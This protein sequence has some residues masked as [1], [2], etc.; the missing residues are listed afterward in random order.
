[1]LTKILR[2]HLNPQRLQAQYEVLQYRMGFLTKKGS[3]LDDRPKDEPAYLNIARIVLVWGQRER[4]CI[5]SWKDE[6]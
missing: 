1:M 4:R 2:K 5:P 3:I 6:K